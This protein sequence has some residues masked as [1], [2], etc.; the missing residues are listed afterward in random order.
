MVNS[1]ALSVSPEIFYNFSKSGTINFKSSKVSRFCLCTIILDLWLSPVFLRRGIFFAF[2]VYVGS[3]FLVCF[4]IDFFSFVF[5]Q[6]TCRSF[7]CFAFFLAK[8]IRPLFNS[9]RTFQ[10]FQSKQIP[11]FSRYYFLGTGN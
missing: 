1:T 9:N 7:L 6:F 2:F 4:E 10:R 8:I 3:L 11:R 5:F